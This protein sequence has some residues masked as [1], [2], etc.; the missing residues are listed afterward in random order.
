MSGKNDDTA[1][2]MRLLQKIVDS[3]SRESGEPLPRFWVAY[4]RRTRRP[5]W[6]KRQKNLKYNRSCGIDLLRSVN[7]N[8]VPLVNDKGKT[9]MTVFSVKTLPLKGPHVDSVADRIK[10]QRKVAALLRQPLVKQASAFVFRVCNKLLS[11]QAICQQYDSIDKLQSSLRNQDLSLDSTGYKSSQDELSVAMGYQDE[12]EQG[13]SDSSFSKLL[14]E[15]QQIIVGEV[16]R[17]KNVDKFVNFGVSYAYV[18]DILARQ[19]PD[20]KFVGVDRSMKTKRYNE[21]IFG[22]R[23]NLHFEAMDIRSFLTVDRA[24]NGVFFHA[25]TATY[26]ARPILEEIYAAARG[27]GYRIV[28]GFEPFG[29]SRVTGEACEFS[30]TEKESL[31]YLYTMIVHNYPEVIRKQGY[32]LLHLNVLQIDHPHEDHRLLEFVARC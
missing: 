16:L 20:V 31:A 14:Y 22:S 29:M 5:R 23:P 30:L 8:E 25:R 26:V 32:E 4:M 7:E 3:G 24:E 9:N 27:S 18:D 2:N 17:T 21:F 15:R 6:I 10:S 12:I 28:V 11:Y 1:E 19:F 13:L